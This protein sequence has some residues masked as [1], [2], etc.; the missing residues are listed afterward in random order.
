MNTIPN[1]NE[2]ENNTS[3]NVQYIKSIN[4]EERK[5]N[6]SNSSFTDYTYNEQLAMIN[7]L[8]LNY[9][10]ILKTRSNNKENN[11]NNTN[12]SLAIQ[13]EIT[14]KISGYKQQDIKNEIYEKE[15]LINME[16][17][18]EKMVASK[19]KCLYCKC[20]VNIIYKCVREETQW[21]LDRVDNDLC[22]SSSN[23]IVSCLKCNL[24]RRNINKEKF[25]FTRNL[26]I[27][28]MGQ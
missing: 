1:I 17:I 12:L 10:T 13:R 16:D 24:K 15:L 27:K 14:R 11:D 7:K 23:T 9:E 3:K 22:H 5:S 25:L 21:T 26:K 4:N 18:L 2:I 8:Y 20:I 6:N 28:K 19:L